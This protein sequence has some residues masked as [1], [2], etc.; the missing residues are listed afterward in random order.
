[1]LLITIL[2]NADRIDAS[3]RKMLDSY[4]KLTSWQA[5]ISQTNYFT[6]SKVKLASSG[7]FYYMKNRIAIRYN[8][9]N[10]QVLLIQDKKVTI[11]DKSSNSVIKSQLSSAVQSLNPVEIVSSYWQKSEKK[12]LP[13]T[14]KTSNI[15]LKH[16]NDKQIREI[17]FTSDNQT[18]YITK[19]IYNDLQGNSVTIAFTKIVVNKTI[20]ASVWKLNIPKT[21]QV[22][23]R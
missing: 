18:G 3:Y 11:Y 13:G 12:L 23:E 7:N 15:Q 10:E 19:L 21:A 16:K 1:M 4:G 14:E 5:V 22:F 17:I 9:P 2:L 6:D 20:P 8:K